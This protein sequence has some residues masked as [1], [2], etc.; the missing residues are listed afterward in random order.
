MQ[1]SSVVNVTTLLP[2]PPLPKG[3]SGHA[4]IRKQTSSQGSQSSTLPALC[5]RS[6]GVRQVWAAVWMLNLA[7]HLP[8]WVVVRDDETQ[9]RS[10]RDVTWHLADTRY[11]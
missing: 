3:L 9:M 4:H 7:G 5:V 6:E 8:P 10:T 11:T 1:T 2:M